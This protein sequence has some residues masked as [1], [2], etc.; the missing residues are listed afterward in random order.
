MAAQSFSFFYKH[1]LRKPYV[2]P[3]KLYPRKEHTLPEI[4]SQQQAAHLFHAVKNIKHRCMIGLLYGAGLRLNELRLLKVNAIDSQAMQIK[5]VQ[6]KGNKDRFTILPKFILNDLRNYYRQNRT[7]E[8]LFEG[9][10]PDRPMHER[11]IGHAV[12]QCMKVAGFKDKGFSAHTLRH[13]FA[14]H[15]LDNG[16]D[17]HT[18]K[19]LLGHTKLE[20]T[21][22]Y[23]HLQQSKRAA[24]VSPL[25]AI[26]NDSQKV[27]S[28]CV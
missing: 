6:G 19:E 23:L 28:S 24:I 9:Y 20:T 15:L 4:L 3:S 5:V 10:I 7:K 8:F 22:I 14:T 17:I 1:V 2:L 11:A 13:S 25:D 16:C 27:V 21:M 26:M 12:T 18:I